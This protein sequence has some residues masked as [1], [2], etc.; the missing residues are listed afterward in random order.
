VI[1]AANVLQNTSNH[2]FTDDDNTECAMPVECELGVKPLQWELGVDKHSAA[3]KL[4]VTDP[5]LCEEWKNL[6]AQTKLW[7]KKHKCV[8]GYILMDYSQSLIASIVLGLIRKKSFKDFRV[9]TKSSNKLISECEDF[10]KSHNVAYDSSY[11]A[12]ELCIEEYFLIVLNHDGKE[13]YSFMNTS[14]SPYNTH[15]LYIVLGPNGRYFPSLKK[16]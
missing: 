11:A 14:G 10:L 8:L 2:T 4:T 15:N 16:L 7:Q 13:L 9:L 12:L 1:P 6:E 5:Y 3:L